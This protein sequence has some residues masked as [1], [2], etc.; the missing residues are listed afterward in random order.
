MSEDV[1]LHVPRLKRQ[2]PHSTAGGVKQIL[3]FLYHDNLT[4]NGQTFQCGAKYAH[5]C[6]GNGD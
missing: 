2:L 4:V 3:E 5:A 1:T 6:E